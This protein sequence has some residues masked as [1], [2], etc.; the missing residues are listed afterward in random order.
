MKHL[1]LYF[2]L[3]LLKAYTSMNKKRGG[4]GDTQHLKYPCLITRRWGELSMLRS[5][6]IKSNKPGS[7]TRAK[8][9]KSRETRWGFLHKTA[10]IF[11]SGS[12]TVGEASP[13]LSSKSQKAVLISAPCFIF[14]RFLVVVGRWESGG[15]TKD[16]VQQVLI[17]F[18]LK[19]GSNC[20]SACHKSRPAALSWL[21]LRS[22]GAWAGWAVARWSL[23][24]PEWWGVG[25]MSNGIE[26]RGKRR[27]HGSPCGKRVPAGWV[28]PANYPAFVSWCQRRCLVCLFWDN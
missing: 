9:V 20:K 1:F 5:G 18:S 3:S 27:G 28:N 22:L 8:K 16:T 25:L 23:T 21:L 6:L 2:H 7:G 19:E 17:F 10:P 15:D 26:H 13:N 4:G 24:P 12:T 11:S 14:L